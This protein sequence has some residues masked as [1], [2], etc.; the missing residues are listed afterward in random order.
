MTR[1]TSP[2]LLLLASCA[3][4]APLPALSADAGPDRVGQPGQRF[5]FD[6][7][8]SAGEGLA[9]RWTL[10]DPS[11]DAVDLGQRA[12]AAQIT[13]TLST[14][15]RWLATVEVCD[16]WG[17]CV[18]DSAVGVVSELQLLAN[19]PPEPNAGPDQ[20]V[21]VG[22]V[23]TLDGTL[24]FD[25]EGEIFGWN[26]A[27][28]VLP[29]GSALTSSDIV[30]RTMDM[31][32]FTP[33]AQ[34][35]YTLRLRV[36]D[37]TDT[38]IDRVNITASNASNSAPVANAGADTTATL[39]VPVSVSG[40][41]TDAD[42][43][44]VTYKWAFRTLP[45]GSALGNTSLVNR[46]S[47][48]VSFT[49]D[50]RGTYELKLTASDGLATGTDFVKV[51]A[52]SGTNSTPVADAGEDDNVLVGEAAVVDAT[53]SSDADGDLLSYRWTFSSVPAGSALVTADI[54]DR[55]TEQASFTPDVTGVY[56]LKLVADDGLAVGRD[57]V[58]LTAYTYGFHEDV[59]PI[60]LSRCAS[61]HTGASPPAG[62]N[63]NA[64]PYTSTVDVASTQL[65]SMDLV[66]PGLSASSYL[67]HK[68]ANTHLGVGG[69]GARM[70]KT[71]GALSAGDLLILKTW[72]D[73]GAPN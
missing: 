60:F 40:S 13:H 23:V 22:D 50:V 42:G 54:Q 64:S 51:S 70:P 38:A 46:T 35:L 10:L 27:F 47:A 6:A 67:Y 7:S 8:D 37:G 24:T 41:A 68:V 44:A 16:L 61:C 62:L 11:G 45:A 26:W 2:A 69:S 31:A 57:T 17:R 9:L 20:S 14:P 3:P 33:D 32:S 59:R 63:L 29:A 66:E 5:T 58:V 56:E 39:G 55:L 21:Y 28:T 15:G 1:L 48:T 36:D 43:D 30:D 34:G 71:G 12:A 73:E 65:P 72:I 4:Q 52:S 53:G 19:N 18:E 49:P 25:L